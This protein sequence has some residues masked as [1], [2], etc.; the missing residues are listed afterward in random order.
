[1]RTPLAWLN[2]AH[3]KTRTVLAVAG[4]VFAVVLIFLQLGFLG[5]A[6]R[7]AS[8]VYEMLDFDIVI[9]SPRY[10]HMVDARTFSR[11]RLYQ[12]ASV[13][14]VERVSAFYLA[15]DYWTNPRNGHKRVI[16]VLGVDPDKAA[17]TIPELQE[18]SQL[19]RVPEFALIDRLS[20]SEFGPQ[21][22]R[23]FGDADIDVEAEVGQAP[24]RIAGHFALGAG[25]V[26][27]G[28]VLLSH[29]GFCRACPYQKPEEVNLGL[30]KVQPGASVTEVRAR[31][32]ATL[33]GDVEI[34]TRPEAIRFEVRRWVQDTSLGVIF[35]LGVVVALV[36]GAAIVYQ[37][38]SSDVASHLAEYATLKAVG[39]SGRFLAGVVFQQALMLALLGFVPGLLLAEVLYALTSYVAKVPV[40][41][42]PQRVVFVLGLSIAM[43]TI[44][45]LGAL[46]KVRT[47]D[48]ADLF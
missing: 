10:L 33:P 34:L 47:A 15:S 26:A 48:P 18:K 28:A 19:L 44:S 13:P 23:R 22:G 21:D 43:C 3:N 38:L 30:L 16:L 46:R 14:G 7:S 32:Q 4:V 31:L 40:V 27:D 11:D 2:L 45:G 9:R 1:M 20:R 12:A 37:I 35:Q 17:F 8:L 36:V 39:Y 42:T 29:E 25:F 6:E 24:V 41:M 5:S